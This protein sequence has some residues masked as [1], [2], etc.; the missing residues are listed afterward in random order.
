[1]TSNF[2]VIFKNYVISTSRVSRI[3]QTG[4]TEELRSFL[5]IASYFRRFINIFSETASSLYALLKKNVPFVWAEECETS[6]NKLRA[7]LQTAAVLRHDKPFVLTTEASNQAIGFTLLQDINGE[8]VPIS[9]GGRVLT[10]HEKR[11]STTDKELLAVYFAVKK[12]ES[13]LIG[14]TLEFIPTTNP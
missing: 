4:N 9:Y 10:D 1:M 2:N 14:H 6:Y 11:Y 12:L 5:G 8:L 13:Y 7:W 3:Q